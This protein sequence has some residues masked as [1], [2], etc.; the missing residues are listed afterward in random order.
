M[1]SVS[2]P[3]RRYSRYKIGSS[4]PNVAEDQELGDEPTIFE[5]DEELAEKAQLEESAAKAQHKIGKL[6][7]ATNKALIGKYNAN[8]TALQNLTGSQRKTKNSCGRFLSRC[9]S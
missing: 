8:T 5:F 9:Q 6:P 7:S 4:K 2:P 1:A 3:K